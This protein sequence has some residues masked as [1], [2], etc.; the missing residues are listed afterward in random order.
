MAK[1]FAF[2]RLYAGP[3]D[4]VTGY[5]RDLQRPSCEYV[6][7]PNW[8]GWLSVIDGRYVLPPEWGQQGWP[9]AD[10]WVARPRGTAYINSH[11]SWPRQLLVEAF[12]SRRAVAALGPFSAP[13]KS[14][15]NMPWPTARGPTGVAVPLSK[16]AVLRQH[17]FVLAVENSAERGYVTEKLLQAHLAG[18]V[19]VYWGGELPPEVAVFNPARIILVD[20]R[21]VGAA[22]AATARL[23]R[24]PTA[25]A[26]FFAQPIAAPGAAAEVARLADAWFGAFTWAWTRAQERRGRLYRT[27]INGTGSAPATTPI[28]RASS[29]RRS[30]EI[31]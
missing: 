18:A 9:G 14:F 23:V 21:K 20:P 26:A 31:E 24:D 19:P 12:T 27:R 28:S 6:R 11:A 10:A 30:D 17:R 29:A 25:R 3:A 15:R 5:R 7:V 16:H 22:V 2:N 13:G 8:V 4:V 1:Y